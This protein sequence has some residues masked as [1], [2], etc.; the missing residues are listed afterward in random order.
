MLAF[1]AGVLS[2]ASPCV[3]P[4]VPGYLSFV[5]GGEVKDEARPVV[6]ILLFIAGFG[7]V[8]TALGAFSSVLVAP[9]KSDWGLRI[10]G[11]VIMT[12]GV[13]MLIYA[14]RLRVP[15]VYME[16][17]PLLARVKPGKTGA[18]ALGMAFAVGWT[19]CIGPVLGT[20]LTLAGNS[21]STIRGAFLLLLYSVGLGVPFLLVGLGVRKLVTGLDWV[22][23]NYH[24]ITGVSGAIMVLIGLLM[25]T[26]L[27]MLWLN[28]ILQRLQN[29]APL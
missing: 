17:R 21:G 28:P 11:L 7:V 10:S 26:G 14:F 19:P 22:G 4:L 13:I 6:P 3:F 29:I 25:L 9:L 1:A 20:I 24:W 5:A 27:W 16:K 18:F 8:F 15:A 12:F 23:R 2:F